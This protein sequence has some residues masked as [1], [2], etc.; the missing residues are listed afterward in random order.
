MKFPLKAGAVALAFC[1]SA[2]QAQ[3]QNVNVYTYREP[4]LIK[5]LFDAFT[6]ET[7][8][9]VNIVFAKEGLEERIAAEGTRSPADLLITT[10]VARLVRAA[11]LGLAQPITDPAIINNVPASL[12]APNGD[13]VGL[14]YRARVVYVSKDRVKDTALTYES[15]ADPKWKGKLCSRDG[16]HIYNNML[17]SAG[18][19][20]LGPEKAEA[21]LKG[22]K[23]N[24]AKK[25]SGGDREVAKDIASG[26]CDIGLGNTYYVGLMQNK[27][28]DQKPWADAIRVILP[29][30]VG[31]GTHVNLSGMALMK[32]APNRANALKLGEWLVGP[33][34][35][36]MYTS[37]NYEFP[38]RK[39]V[40]V[41][42]AVANFG[43]LTPDPISFDAIIGARKTA[44]DL[45]DQ[46]GYNGGPG[47]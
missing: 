20:H 29:T 23:T 28:P 46:I 15:L 32:S 35:Q 16:Q 33:E 38:V 10:D 44:S 42:P 17:F 14:S 22:M 21:W 45:I 31:G 11:Q 39:D 25:P 12:R 5:P 19:V 41:D 3:T 24:L 30:F 6:K 43:V 18:V 13:W 37:D 4:G 34:A 2:A 26:Q 40:P 47:S 27:S 36:K 1:A 7:G 9:Q 8:I